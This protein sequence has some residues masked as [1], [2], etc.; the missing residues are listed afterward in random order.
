MLSA[1]FGGES[2]WS[3]AV[4]MWK[5]EQEVFLFVNCRTE[6]SSLYG[7]NLVARKTSF[8]IVFM[9]LNVSLNYQASFERKF[10]LTSADCEV[11]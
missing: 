11:L 1:I 4:A 9:S 10:C 5:D 7:A 2:G 6:H 3:A 8:L